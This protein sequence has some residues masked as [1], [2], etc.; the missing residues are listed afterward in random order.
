M[1]FMVVLSFINDSVFAGCKMTAVIN[2]ETGIKQ[3]WF[4]LKANIEKEQS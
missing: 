1:Q 3:T 2:E 4:R